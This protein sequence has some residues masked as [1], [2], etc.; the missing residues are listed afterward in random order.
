MGVHLW[1]VNPFENSKHKQCWKQQPGQATIFKTV[2]KSKK[3]PRKIKKNKR[4]HVVSLMSLY[5][6][7]M[8][9]LM[10]RHQE[11]FNQ[12]TIRNPDVFNDAF[13]KIQISCLHICI[14]FSPVWL[15][16]MCDCRGKH[17]SC[18]HRSGDGGVRPHIWVRWRMWVQSSTAYASMSALLDSLSA[19]S[20]WLQQQFVQ[21]HPSVSFV[22]VGVRVCVCVDV[23]ACTTV[24]VGF[25]CDSEEKPSTIAGAVCGTL[26]P[27]LL[28]GPG[29]SGEGDE[30]WVGVS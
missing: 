8:Q 2:Y 24:Y 16:V 14:C 4:K 19:L 18:S 28:V 15:I 9:N 22:S 1:H 25:F 26:L 17:Q 29:Q 21:L 27:V 11:V 10:C 6:R 5:T 20:M 12:K 3:K 30:E 23:C 13:K 7:F